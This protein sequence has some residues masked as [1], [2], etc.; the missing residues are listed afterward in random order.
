MKFQA[1]LISID[2]NPHLCT[3]NFS[4]KRYST[5]RQRFIEYW[6][7]S[8]VSVDAQLKII[9]EFESDYSPDKAILWYTR[10]PFIYE[11]INKALRELDS[12]TIVM[13][14]FL[15]HDLHRQLQKLQT[16]EVKKESTSPMYRGQGLSRKMLRD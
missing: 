2:S 6:R 4:R 5:S 14:A 1:P 7:Q 15:L 8:S 3:R 9:D 10:C 11:N 16:A 12:D 13:M